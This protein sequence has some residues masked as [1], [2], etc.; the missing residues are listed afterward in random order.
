MTRLLT[1][2]A[3]LFALATI[4]KAAEGRMA[5]VDF[6]VHD[7]HFE[8]NKSGLKGD[9]SYLAITDRAGF[10]AV[11][12]TAAVMGKKFNYVPKD[13]FEKKMVVAVIKRGDAPVDY[14]VEQ[15]TTA[16]DKL[17]LQYKATEKGATTAKFASPLIL[18]VDRG[19]YTSVVFIENGKQVGTATV[20]K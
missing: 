5:K 10:D 1:M 16:D 11:F 19:K 20:G 8:S 17:Y 18:T 3:A 15:V 12:G 6:E 14:T 13:A 4:V 7:G 9:A 2:L